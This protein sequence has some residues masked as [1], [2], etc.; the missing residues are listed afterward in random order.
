MTGYVALLIKLDAMTN[1][2][3]KDIS[4][5]NY[6]NLDEH[7]IKTFKLEDCELNKTFFFA[8][9][10]RLNHSWGSAREA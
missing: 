7:K 3:S 1:T 9:L 10:K 5:G 4:G 8:G 6:C 2:I